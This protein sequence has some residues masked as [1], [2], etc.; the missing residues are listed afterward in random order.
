MP[1]D[2]LLGRDVGWERAGNL[3]PLHDEKLPGLAAL[4]LR[5]RWGGPKSD[6]ARRQDHGC[7]SQRQPNKTPIVDT[8]APTIEISLTRRRRGCCLKFKEILP[9]RHPRYLVH[10][11]CRSALKQPPQC[12]KREGGEIESSST[13]LLRRRRW[14]SNAGS[15]QPWLAG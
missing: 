5:A 9:P 8:A 7:Y 6:A 2:K 12:Q 11:C 14:P 10:S 3:Q 4:G 15:E 13:R 1:L